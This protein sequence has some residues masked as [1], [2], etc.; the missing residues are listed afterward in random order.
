MDDSGRPSKSGESERRARLENMNKAG[1]W[2]KESPSHFVSLYFVK[3]RIA[4]LH[5]YHQ[6]QADSFFVDNVQDVVLKRRKRFE[7]TTPEKLEDNEPLWKVK[8]LN[9]YQKIKRRVF[10]IYLTN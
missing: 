7:E 2:F 9:N 4:E 3:L 5:T 8:E 6:K 1:T 10:D